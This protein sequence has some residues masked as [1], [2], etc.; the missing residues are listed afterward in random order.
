MLQIF[1]AKGNVPA[2]NYNYFIDI[3]LETVRGE[4]ATCLEKAYKKI[5]AHDATRMLNLPSHA[6]VKEYGAKVSG[7]EAENA[8]LYLNLHLGN[9][10]QS[11]I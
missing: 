8:L 11:Y 1:L 7:A 9:N 10:I 6:A 2:K 3:L 4:I 5:S